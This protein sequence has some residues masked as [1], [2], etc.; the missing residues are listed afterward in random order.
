M[1]ENITITIL[2]VDSR[3]LQGSNPVKEQ[4]S[5]GCAPSWGEA[6]STSVP[7]SPSCPCGLAPAPLPSAKAAVSH[8]HPGSVMASPGLDAPTFPS[9]AGSWIALGPPRSA[10]TVSQLKA[11]KLISSVES[12]FSGQILRC[13]KLGRGPATLGNHDCAQPNNHIANRL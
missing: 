5:Q 10:E 3:S 8:C 13:Q 2:C 7:A 12:V 9:P 4:P 11:L 6:T 1:A